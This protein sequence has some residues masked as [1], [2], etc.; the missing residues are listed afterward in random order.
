LKGN[1]LPAASI[2]EDTAK[3]HG[4]PAADATE[5]VQLFIVN[6][7]FLGILRLIAGAERVIPLEQAIEE[8]PQA[9]VADA[10]AATPGPMPAQGIE[11]RAVGPAAGGD[12]T[13]WKSI[14][15]YISPIGDEGSEHRQHADLF[16][17]SIVEP[18]VEEFGLKVVRADRI[19][20]PGMITA[21]IIEHVLKSRLVIADLS[22]HN[23]NVFYELCLSTT[24]ENFSMEGLS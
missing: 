14:C 13:E 5:C 3:E 9:A 6:A 11:R 22:Y 4:V 21:Q 18:A 17:G 24:V 8:L 15:F 10:S 23:P 12:E 2:L 7:K 20:K 19:G 16:L 1:R